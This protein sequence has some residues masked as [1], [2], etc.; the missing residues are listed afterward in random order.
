MNLMRDWRV[1]L[2]EYLKDYF[3]EDVNRFAPRY[4]P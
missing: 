3:A 2:K 4:V 1:A